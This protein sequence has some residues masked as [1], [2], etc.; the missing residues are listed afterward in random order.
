[1]HAGA[2]ASA[3][4]LHL[5]KKQKYLR[6][7]LMMKISDIHL[8]DPFVLHESGQ[9]FLYGTRGETAFSRK[10]DGF[11]VYL[12]E[13][14]LEWEGPKVCFSRP[15]DFW[16]TRNFWA[17]E[18]YAYHGAYYMFATFANDG[19]Q[20]GTAVLRA[21][22]PVGPFVPWSQGTIT[23]PDWRCLD[24][25]LYV[26]NGQPYMI[27]SREWKQV[28]DGQIY[29]VALSEDFSR[30]KGT[31]FLL[32]KASQGRPLVKPF[33]FRNYVTDGP[34]TFKTEDGQLHLLWS[35]FGKNGYMQVVAHSDNNL[36]HGNWQTAQQPLF[37]NDGG[38]GMIFRDKTGRA[39]LTLHSPN[40][41][42]KE[43][44]IFVPLKYEENELK[45]ERCD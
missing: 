37:F 26:E 20:L 1:M 16:A 45:V 24:G 41:N 33:L 43:H 35:S 30:A 19:K 3:A 23:P 17:P 12:S 34:F 22:S 14:M 40:R 8:R 21:Q 11:D 38:H 42:P 25:T 39:F 10:A 44:P 29:A 36:L 9:Y 32:F 4:A 6:A 5:E 28:H 18:V 7:G 31:P 27:F 13:D 15:Q 2:V